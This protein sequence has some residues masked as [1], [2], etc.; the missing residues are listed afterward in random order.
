MAECVRM[1]RQGNTVESCLI[2]EW[3]KREGDPVEKGEVLCTVETDKASIDVESEHQ[4]VLLKIL[5]DVDEDVPVL[6]PIAY[7]GEAGEELGEL[8]EEKSPEPMAKQPATQPSTQPAAM[9]EPVKEV[10][11]PR[12]ISPRA[13]KLAREK[14]LS[15][16][17]LSGS[18]PGGRI[19]ER[20]IQAALADRPSLSPAAKNSPDLDPGRLPSR[21]SGVGGRI[22][23][24]DLTAGESRKHEAPAEEWEEIPVKSVRRKIAERMRES[25][26]STAQLTLNAS[27]RA[28]SLLAW[29][30]I[31]KAADPESGLCGI[32]INDLLIFALAKTLPDFPELNAHFL[33]DRIRRFSRV[34]IGFAVDT[35]RGLMVPVIRNADSSSLLE[36]SRESKRLAAACREGSIQPD[37]LSGAT[38]TLSNLGAFGIESF[39]PVLNPP[40]V[41]ILGVCA[42]EPK[43]VIEEGCTAFYPHIGLSLTIDHQAVDGAPGARFLKELSKR[44]GSYETVAAR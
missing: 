12:A 7:I 27:A 34:H 4:G 22:L 3:H 16:E 28:D 30:K 37:E 11:L 40:E 23:S 20:D 35:P 44:L 18:G 24:R 41:A 32:S 9:S 29:R 21:G 19:I 14:G 33:G 43:A 13:R 10:S 25:L 17:G 1:P 39:T 2:I 5:R 38:I 8:E 15:F 6:E 36:I 42:I 26:T 31:F